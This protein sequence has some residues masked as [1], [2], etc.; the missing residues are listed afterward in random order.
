MKTPFLK[1]LAAISALFTCGLLTAAPISNWTEDSNGGF[2]LHLSGNLS[3]LANGYGQLWS[4]DLLSPSGDWAINYG[5]GFVRRGWDES[6]P[7]TFVANGISGASLAPDRDLRLFTGGGY[8]CQSQTLAWGSGNGWAMILGDD[9]EGW[10]GSTHITF[11]GATNMSDFSTWQWEAD[12]FLRNPSLEQMSPRG[13]NEC[14]QVPDSGASSL[15]LLGISFV[16][17]F[18]LRLRQYVQ[19]SAA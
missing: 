8:A 4:G 1:T 17:F 19:K 3:V 2:S 15:Q 9:S 16:G 13:G 12:I 14:N 7:Y 6:D 10:E 5:G 18:I 11:T